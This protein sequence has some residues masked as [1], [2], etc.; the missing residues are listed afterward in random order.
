MCSF[1]ILFFL[2]I[3]LLKTL[4]KRNLYKMQILGGFK[5]EFLT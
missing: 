4:S 5:L 2:D 3:V 1:K